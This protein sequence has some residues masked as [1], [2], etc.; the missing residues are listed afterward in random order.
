MLLY[1]NPTVERLKI[2]E[3]T[4]NIT[5]TSTSTFAVGDIVQILYSK[6]PAGNCCIAVATISEIHD[7]YVKV[8]DIR[9]FTGNAVMKATSNETTPTILSKIA[10]SRISKIS[11]GE[12]LRDMYLCSYE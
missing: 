6:N 7:T 5:S 12:Y 10:F 8:I 1:I 9:F 2:S 4:M 11:E 3:C